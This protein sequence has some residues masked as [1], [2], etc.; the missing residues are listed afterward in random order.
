[1]LW[2][3]GP[4]GHTVA[5]VEHKELELFSFELGGLGGP[6][7]YPFLLFCVL[8]LTRAVSWQGHLEPLFRIYDPSGEGKLKFEDFKH[9]A[10][11]VLLVE[12]AEMEKRVTNIERMSTRMSASLH[13]AGAVPG[14]GRGQSSP[15][16]PAAASLQE[17]HS[18]FLGVD[19]RKLAQVLH[20][21]Q[22]PATT[23]IHTTPWCTSNVVHTLCV[24]RRTWWFVASSATSH[25]TRRR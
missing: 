24:R 20:L 22:V 7:C 3:E 15:V 14:T 18:V 19:Q 6:V 13:P 16:P 25:R 21:C 4:R 12:A 23:R 9:L 8:A 17:V 2:C 10:V 5:E 11:D 1:M